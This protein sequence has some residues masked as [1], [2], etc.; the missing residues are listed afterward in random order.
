M[1]RFGAE[2]LVERVWLDVKVSCEETFLV[3]LDGGVEEINTSSFVMSIGVG[4]SGSYCI[5]VAEEIN[6]NFQCY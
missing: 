2:V 1:G 3:D 4:T 5:V 6:Y